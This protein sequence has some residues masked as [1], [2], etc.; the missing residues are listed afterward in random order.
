MNSTIEVMNNKENEVEQNILQTNYFD[1]LNRGDFVKQVIEIIENL[2]SQRE[3]MCYAIKGSW[4]VG[5]T[6]VLDMIEKELL[7]EFRQADAYEKYILIHYNAW[8][9]DYYTEPLF[10]MVS[11]MRNSLKREI[12]LISP[13]AIEKI[14][15][16]LDTINDISEK[17]TDTVSL[18]LLLK[19]KKISKDVA[20]QILDSNHYLN[21]LMQEL[22]K[23]LKEQ[24]EDVTIVVV[25]DELDRCLPEYAIKVLERLH[26]IFGNTENTQVILSVDYDQLE[27]T[28]K[29]I[30]GDNTSTKRYLSKFINFSISLDEGHL[31]DN[32][33]KEFSDYVNL[34]KVNSHQNYVV[35]AEDIRQFKNF[36]FEGM[37]M[38]QRKEIVNKSRLI[39]TIVNDNESKE[40]LDESYMCIELV[41][42]LWKLII[43]NQSI[44]FNYPYCFSEGKDHPIKMLSTN[45]PQGLC[46]I[47]RIYEKSRQEY[48]SSDRPEYDYY[49]RGDD[50][51]SYIH[52][53]D[54]WGVI[55]LCVAEIAN[56]NCK[57]LCKSS[58]IG[59]N[60]AEYVNKYWNTLQIIN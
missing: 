45:I 2:A 57:Y 55:L 60:Y 15:K 29:T 39:H 50:R 21:K 24:A 51:N 1:S 4:G 13:K 37:D 5:K 54:I 49:Y 46:E 30:F 56:H 40:K 28:V 3:S 17:I 11:S 41:L 22:K 44:D 32:F 59:D 7:N 20:A 38:R 19:N 53:Y 43:D 18:S 25:V 48:R 8:Q 34:F 27:N 58:Y 14:K 31:A 47:E 26:H 6:H 23:G 9:Y 42:T 12:N 36:I 10:A 52:L 16:F 35:D 33:D